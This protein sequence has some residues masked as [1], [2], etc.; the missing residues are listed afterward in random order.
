MKRLL[1]LMLLCLL[2]LGLIAGS[3]DVNKDGKLDATDITEMVK[4]IMGMC[5]DG[6]H[7]EEADVNNDGQ[8]NTADIVQVVNNIL[9]GDV[10]VPY[11]KA[12]KKEYHIVNQG[13]RLLYIQVD[14]NID[15]LLTGGYTYEIID[16][17]DNWLKYQ[18]GEFQYDNN[19]TGKDREAKIVIS[20]VNYPELTD[21]VKVIQHPVTIGNGASMHTTTC[22]P[23][24][25]IL[26]IP[27]F[28]ITAYPSLD[29]EVS[30]IPF[31]MQRLDDEIRDSN[32]IL[33][34]SI[35]ANDTDEDFI[36]F[37]GGLKI[38]VG[39]SVE[40]YCFWQLGKNASSFEEQKKGL[41]ALYDLTDGANWKNSN[42]WLTD[43]PV[44]QWHGVN[45]DQ[46]GNDTIIGDYVIRLN[47]GENLIKGHIPEQLADLMWISSLDLSGN[48][49]YGK[50][51]D[52]VINHPNWT[53]WGWNIIMQ[54]LW[55][56]DGRLLE[57][58]DLKLM[59]D[60]YDIDHVNGVFTKSN[61]LFAKYKV[62][63]VMI[64]APSDEMVNLHMS[65]QNKG[66]GTIVSSYDW[67]GGKRE[68]LV[69]MINKAPIEIEGIWKCDWASR[70]LSGLGTLGTWYVFDDK[71]NLLACLPRD[72]DV[73][74]K[75]YMQK[76]DSI[77]KARL[78]EPEEHEPYISS[79]YVSEDYSKDG[80]V[81]VLQQA[82][83]G[84]GV[85]L[86][87]MGDAYVDRD[88]DLEGK[89]ETD[90]RK[91]MEEFFAVEPYRSFRNR[92]NVY[93]IKVVSSSDHFGEGYEQRLNF[94]DAICFEYA[95]KIEGVDMDHV[96]IVNIVNKPDYW[97]VGGHTNMYDNGS[98]VA[99][100]EKGGPSNIIVHEA[101]GHGFAK[102]LDE[103]IYAGYEKNHSQEG[104][105]ADFQ[106]WI[107]EAYHDKG[108]GM[109]ISTTDNP[110]EVPWTH[111]LKDERYKDE[112][113][114]FKGAW[115]WPEE[116]WRSSKNSVMNTDYSWFNAPSREAIYKR[117]MKLSEGD[118]WTYDYE[119]FVE[120]DTPAREAYK[121]ARSK[122]RSKG[123][124]QKQ[125]RIESR[126][127]TIYK[128]TW[129]D[130][131]KCE[132]VEY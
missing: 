23:N 6:F 35:D 77:C 103:Y 55:L 96:T 56:S 48:A 2:P 43:K 115:M 4:Y 70:Q 132:K 1:P 62:S 108:W 39:D 88:M 5:S 110:E 87:F 46:W 101:G 127:P 30:T 75:W 117:V 106:N 33:R 105:N 32:R 36:F 49:L 109:N 128:G 34:F 71:A 45:N 102:L 122:A 15:D 12:I 11:I 93:A 80:E 22:Q 31:F 79:Y 19:W 28:G 17:E 10:E 99:H 100:I 130:A 131:G 16:C 20:T 84:K 9:T 98:S 54:N 67:L 38:R 121:Q 14:S 124:H 72:W 111:F 7:E 27:I 83:E 86:V 126:P 78:G 76:V 29:V 65:Y 60:N 69:E 24:G 58:D 91:G 37:D 59:L 50:I 42:N 40:E 3:G 107:K 73:P 68:E 26:E 123:D 18:Y 44:N 95:Q 63:V 8:V 114:I 25:G 51:P 66:Y 118:G 129:R 81:M 64:G 85:D 116:L 74:E 90:M 52:A 89:Y 97:W 92:F 82:T 125:R 57:A 41:K 119:T 120:F 53:K 21:I 112:V 61:D 47:L 94:D 13:Y 113:G 104:A